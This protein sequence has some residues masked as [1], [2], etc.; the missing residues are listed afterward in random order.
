MITIKEMSKILKLKQNT[1]RYWLD[2]NKKDFSLNLTDIDLSSFFHFV[3][4]NR[5]R[6]CT[7]LEPDLFIQKFNEYKEQTK[8]KKKKNRETRK[9]NWTYG[10]YECWL[11]KGNCKLCSNNFFC[12]RFSDPPMKKLIFELLK[13]IGEPNA[14][15]ANLQGSTHR[16]RK[17]KP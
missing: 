16:K 13:N 2:K 4:T 9:Y 10:A 17:F 12:S 3:K 15:I 14:Y 5:K 7:F 1:F 6:F 11:L 8:I